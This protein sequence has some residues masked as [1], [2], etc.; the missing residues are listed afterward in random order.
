MN[1]QILC[2]VSATLAYEYVCACVHVCV[3]VYVY[4]CVCVTECAPLMPCIFCTVQGKH[5]CTYIH[6]YTDIMWL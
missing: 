2:A 5:A 3:Y 1:A 6:I 4:T